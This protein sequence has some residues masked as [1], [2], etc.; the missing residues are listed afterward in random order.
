MKELR[1]DLQTCARHWTSQATKA[2]SNKPISGGASPLF[3][4]GQ[5]RVAS[6]GLTNFLR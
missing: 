5:I 3:C 1:Q 6:G 4:A 2:I